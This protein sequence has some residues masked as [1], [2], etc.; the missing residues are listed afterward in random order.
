MC[1]IYACI[2]MCII[3]MYDVCVLTVY[4]CVCTCMCVHTMCVCICICMWMCVWMDGWTDGWMDG[5]LVVVFAAVPTCLLQSQS[6]CAT[7]EATKYNQSNLFM[8]WSN[9]A[10][11]M[12]K[13]YGD[14]Q[15]SKKT[16][17]PL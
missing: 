13:V 2:H 1:N 6:P 8:Y 4:V 17:L 9:L 15:Q 7:S 10:L 11:R 16:T 3:C 14:Q 5:K 12:F